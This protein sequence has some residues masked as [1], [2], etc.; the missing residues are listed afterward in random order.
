MFS[1]K[2]YGKNV[3]YFYLAGDR[4]PPFILAL[5]MVGDPCDNQQSVTPSESVIPSLAYPSSKAK[6]KY[7]PPLLHNR[8]LTHH[9]RSETYPPPPFPLGCI[10]MTLVADSSHHTLNSWRKVCVGVTLLRRNKRSF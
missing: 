6:F 5:L 4:N 10:C 2:D 1:V 9:R 7:P 3:I 8:I